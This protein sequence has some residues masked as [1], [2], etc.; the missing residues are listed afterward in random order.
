MNELLTAVGIA[1]GLIGYAPYIRDI[2]RGKTRPHVYT[3]FSWGLLS[4]TTFALQLSDH[5]GVGAYITLFVALLC[6]VIFGLALKQ[7]DHD[8]TLSDTLVFFVV[9]VAIG[10]WLFAKQPILS[11]LLVVSADVLAFLPTVRKSWRKPRQETLLSYVF[12]GS[13]HA[14]AA[15]ALQ[16]FTFI[17]ALSPI[18]LMLANGLFVLMLVARRYA[19]KSQL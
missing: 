10:L 1:L 14:V 8:I 18:V 5:A 19:I 15:L 4:S 16:R 2:V 17:T 12:A 7:G 9:L 6:F 3:W 13:R 11:I